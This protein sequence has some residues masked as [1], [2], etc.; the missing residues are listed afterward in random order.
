MNETELIMDLIIE[1]LLDSESIKSDSY[2]EVASY[3]NL[4][5]TAIYDMVKKD[6]ITIKFFKLIKTDE[7][8]KFI[9]ISENYLINHILMGI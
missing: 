9:N 6:R 8:L 2:R 4:S 3:F 1:V 5:H 7:Q